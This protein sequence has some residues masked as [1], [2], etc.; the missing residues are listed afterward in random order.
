MG[1]VKRMKFERNV[2]VYHVNGE[3]YKGQI[4]SI[5]NSRSEMV[6]DVDLIITNG[7]GKSFDAGKYNM[8][9]STVVL[10]DN[11]E[12]TEF[13]AMCKS[14]I[15]TKMKLLST[16]T[17][18][19][20][21][22]PFEQR[23][24][25]CFNSTEELLK[26]M[27][28][29]STEQD[30][31]I[32]KIVYFLIQKQFTY[33]GAQL[34]ELEADKVIENTTEL[35]KNISDEVI[36]DW[37]CRKITPT[38]RKIYFLNMKGGD[39]FTAE[40]LQENEQWI[41]KYKEYILAYCKNS[42]ACIREVR[43]F[44]ED[45]KRYLAVDLFLNYLF[46]QVGANLVVKINGQQVELLDE[47]RNNQDIKYNRVMRQNTA[48]DIDITD[49]KIRKMEVYMEYQGQQIPIGIKFHKRR[50]IKQLKKDIKTS[51]WCGLFQR[52]DKW[53]YIV[54]Y[55]LCSSLLKVDPNKV[56]MVSDSRQELSGNFEFLDQEFKKQGRN[57]EYFFKRT[58]GEKKSACEKFKLCKM[59]A[60][61]KNIIVDDFYPIVYT[62]KIRDKT[63]LIQIWHAMGAFKR[64]GFS[65][66][67]KIGGPSP[68]SLTHR[69]Y[70]MAITSSASIRKDYAEAFGIDIAKVHGVGVPRTD[71]F[72]DI[73]YANKVKERLYDSYPMLK[74][75]KVILFAPTFRGN[76]QK[77]AKYN[78]DWM[79]YDYI[80]KEFG[81]EYIFINKLHPFIKN[82]VE[83]PEH[84]M[85]LDMTSEREINDL[86]FITD[87]LIT[88]YSSV[89]FEASLLDIDT[90][91]YVPDYEIYTQGRDFY[92]EFDK[93]TYGTVAYNMQGLVEALHNPGND[94]SKLEKF[95]QYFCEACDGSSTK[96]MVEKILNDEVK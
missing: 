88:D 48:Y 52:L 20:F 10:E 66:M 92:Y 78:F 22:E 62:L 23:L 32:S 18:E 45:N 24:E 85:F 91:F 43:L 63:N 19:E 95:K 9:V 71:I 87:I 49:I 47:K 75:K 83:L 74:D 7:I 13:L 61:S 84:P 30:S 5:I 39:M 53:Q 67:G 42:K 11:I 12:R 86:L 77:S 37:S 72:F 70:D 73:N 55:N 26:I 15:R 56:C 93:Y 35:L 76:G 41:F 80:A 57:V 28:S 54:L 31:I 60:T 90:V 3:E 40:L 4:D 69:N 64:V 51:K 33:T 1:V 81:E 94:V 21:T 79:D 59:M 89:I 50:I 6:T 8:D 36:V 46:I 14:L 29:R 82:V 68:H 58:L 65:R 2:I 17:Y 44:Q 38:Y 25:I 34:T 16:E 27:A 96:K